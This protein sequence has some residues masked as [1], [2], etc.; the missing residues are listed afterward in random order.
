MGKSK[1]TDPAEIER[2][3]AISREASR[4]YRARHPERYKAQTRH[5]NLRRYGITA[6]EYDDLLTAQSGVCAIC[7]HSERYRDR[8]RLAVDHCHT[9]G[10]V[11]GLLCSACNKGI[12][13]F[14]DDPAILE[15]AIDYLHRTTTATPSP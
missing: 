3:R 14:E 15:R 5:Q 11:R 2:R 10:R 13:C 1:P 9:T 4:R 6:Q 12:G 8:Q 7:G